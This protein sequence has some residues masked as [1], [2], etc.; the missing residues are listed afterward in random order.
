MEKK[1]EGNRIANL[2]TDTNT[3]STGTQTWSEI[4]PTDEVRPPARRGHTMVLDNNNLYVFGGF[5]S[6]DEIL[7]DV[8]QFNLGTCNFILPIC[9]S[10]S[11]FQLETKKWTSIS[12]TG[13]VP[14]ARFSHGACVHK[15]IM[16]VFAG[17]GDP[18]LYDDL[19]QFDLG[20]KSPYFTDY[21]VMKC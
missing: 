16:W 20:K 17:C 12:Y 13:A 1:K 18:T 21:L 15:G 4:V 7:N 11:T 5:G 14:P 8:Y 3:H 10:F 19:Y 6:G 2:V 9:N